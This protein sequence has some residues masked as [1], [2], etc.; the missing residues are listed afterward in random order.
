[1]APDEAAFAVPSALTA[2]LTDATHIDLRWQ[3]NATEPVGYWVE[4]KTPGADFVKLDLVSPP[5]CTFQHADVAPDT[6]FV[7]RVLPLFGRPSRTV[8][9]TT[10]QAPKTGEKLGEEGPLEEPGSNAA[11][12]ASAGQSVRSTA[13]IANAAPTHLTATRSSPTSVELRWED[14]ASDED[15]YLV[16]LSLDETQFRAAALLPP[17][18]TSFRKISLPEKTNVYFR[19]RAFFYGE[20]SRFAAVTTPGEDALPAGQPA[21]TAI[22]P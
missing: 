4:F 17:N 6:T 8:T 2:T 7:Y 5:T 21:G 20:P 19:V 16:E 22:K 11:D 10:G 9:I 1:M 3:H 12:A 14:R 15:G 18:T 13:T